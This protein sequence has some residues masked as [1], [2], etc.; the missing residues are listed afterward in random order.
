MELAR[1]RKRKLKDELEKNREPL[2][3]MDDEIARL[4]GELDSLSREIRCLTKERAAK[5]AKLE[6]RLAP[7]ENRLSTVN[8]MEALVSD[9]HAGVKY[10][11]I[12]SEMCPEL[13]GWVTDI[14]ASGGVEA[15]NPCGDAT[16]GAGGWRE[17]VSEEGARR[18]V[19]MSFLRGREGSAWRCRAIAGTP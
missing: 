18:L 1:E 9:E 13:A 8:Q 7:L 3:V 5:R 14:F 15:P 19:E 4:E 16:D 10:V 6:D 11:V 2:R 17:W 12:P